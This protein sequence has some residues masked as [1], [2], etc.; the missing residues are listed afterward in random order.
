MGPQLRQKIL[1]QFPEWHEQPLRL[2]LD[3][4]AAPR[5]VI[6]EF[7]ETYNLP[8]IRACLRQWLDDAIRQ[9][10]VA[11]ADHMHTCGHVEKLVEAAWLLRTDPPQQAPTAPSAPAPARQEGRLYVQLPFFDSIQ[12]NTF[13]EVVLSQGKQEGIRMEG[14]EE[15]LQAIETKVNDEQTLLIEARPGYADEKEKLEAITLYITCCEIRLLATSGTGSIRCAGLIREADVRLVQNGSGHIELEVETASLQAIIHGSGHVRVKGRSFH[16]H[17]ITYGP[18]T[19]S[20]D[21]LQNRSAT[22]YL[23]GSGEVRLQVSSRLEGS[24]SGTG[25][26]LYRGQPAM[27]A[28]FL[29]DGA[30]VR[31]LDDSEPE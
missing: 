9:D 31:S 14:P 17:I 18:G 15:M 30:N 4:M 24:V 19:F 26:L 12:L 10:D 7:F 29:A 21:Q 25:A 11:A 22:V 8:A 27:K 13:C 20:G 1:T 28:L 23:S 3:E 6:A 5:Q 16:A 2:T